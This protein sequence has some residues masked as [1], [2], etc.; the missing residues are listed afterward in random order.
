MQEVIA[1][2]Y[3]WTPE[4]L[5]DLDLD[6]LELWEGRARARIEFMTATRC[7]FR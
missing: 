6:Q 3:G 5:D 4:Q 2:V 1:F 7:A